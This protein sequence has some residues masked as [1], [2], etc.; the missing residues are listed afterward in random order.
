MTYKRP[1]EKFN[2]R[3]ALR[4]DRFLMYQACRLTSDIKFRGLS[5]RNINSG[6]CF[7]W[8]TIVFD[9]I[10]GSKIA[11]QNIRGCGHT[12]I[13]YKGRLYDA[14]VPNGVRNWKDLPFWKRLKAEAG[15]KDWNK[16]LKEA[17]L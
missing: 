6:Q 9:K 17:K 15:T 4:W 2:K 10:A 14:E 16:A 12:W 3:L 1:L 8:A 5:A 11:G 13:E 7:E